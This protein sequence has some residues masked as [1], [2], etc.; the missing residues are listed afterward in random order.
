[1]VNNG[2]LNESDLSVNNCV[3][4]VQINPEIK[5]I[6]ISSGIVH[7]LTIPEVTL[8]V[9]SSYTYNSCTDSSRFK[10][11][12]YVKQYSSC[13]NISRNRADYSISSNIVRAQTVPEINL[14]FMSRNIVRA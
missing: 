7:A 1:L 3:V 9:R 6:A 4:H 10:A 2:K 12:R 11:F 8:V 14:F 13:I 5:V